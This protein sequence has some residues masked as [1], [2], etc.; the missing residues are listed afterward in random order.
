MATCSSERTKRKKKEKKKK[1]PD[2]NLEAPPASIVVPSQDFRG[3]R[4]YLARV[5][6]H[7][8]FPLAEARNVKLAE[9][10]ADLGQGRDSRLFV[11]VLLAIKLRAKD[12][13]KAN[14]EVSK[15]LPCSRAHIGFHSG[16]HIPRCPKNLTL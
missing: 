2:K 13:H 9:A 1:G 15:C 7:L 16:V 4:S 11:D 6:D 3:R 8:D 5:H 14:G 10:I 12:C